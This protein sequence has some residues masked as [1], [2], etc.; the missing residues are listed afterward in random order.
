MPCERHALVQRCYQPNRTSLG[1]RGTE[2]GVRYTSRRQVVPGGP[3]AAICPRFEPSWE[4]VVGGAGSGKSA[5]AMTTAISTS[6]I[7]GAISGRSTSPQGCS[8]ILLPVWQAATGAERHL[9]LRDRCARGHH[10]RP[11]G[12]VACAGRRTDWA[13][14]LRRLRARHCALPCILV[15]LATPCGA[16]ST[17]RR[18][19]ASI[20]VRLALLLLGSFLGHVRRPLDQ[21]PQG[22]LPGVGSRLPRALARRSH[23]ILGNARCGVSVSVAAGGSA[24]APS[25]LRRASPNLDAFP[26]NERTGPR[27]H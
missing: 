15:Q 14:P 10:Q 2:V 23:I 7:A 13:G 11:A 3:R 12:R 4:F 5:A 18:F 17:R 16:A 22:E 8:G 6:S 26:R 25:A 21:G 19:R 1:R 9:R 27:R 20:R 24:S